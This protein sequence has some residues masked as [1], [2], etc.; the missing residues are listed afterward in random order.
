[1]KQYK[2]TPYYV[3][4]CGRVFRKGK[5]KPLIPDISKTGYC[6]VTLCIA[7][8][9]TRLL[10]HRMVAEVY[11]PNPNLCDF[12]NHIDNT[13]YNNSKDNLEWV[14]HSENMLH[15]HVQRRGSNL[16]AS[17]KASE[18]HFDR[19]EKFYKKLLGVNF[20]ELINE[21]PRNYVKYLCSC[22][23]VLCKSRTDSSVFKND[24]IECRS[25]TR[26]MKI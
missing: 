16:V 13:P 14:T 18:Q 24:K 1:M 6:R 11:L 4:E 20:V 15:C 21:Y 23:Q 19:S 5:I 2:N 22:C 8:I 25:C 7:G 17:A 12:V 10:V 9:T 26:R 3:T